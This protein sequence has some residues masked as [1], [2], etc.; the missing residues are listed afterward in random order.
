MDIQSLDDEDY[1]SM[2]SVYDK[3]KSYT[4]REEVE[5]NE[6]KLISL[7]KNILNASFGIELEVNDRGSRNNKC[8]NYNNSTKCIRAKLWSKLAKQ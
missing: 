2:L 6:N 3:K 4:D 1:E 8:K 5:G 7:A